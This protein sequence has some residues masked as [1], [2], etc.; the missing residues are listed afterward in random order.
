MTE[1]YKTLSSM[2]RDELN[3]AAAEIMLALEAKPSKRSDTISYAPPLGERKN[4]NGIFSASE[5]E[6]FGSESFTR[7]SDL[8]LEAV[9]SFFERDSRRY[10][11]EFEIY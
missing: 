7:P 3:T 9:S 1:L 4:L 2:S 10:D 5:A 8:D 11:K 6:F